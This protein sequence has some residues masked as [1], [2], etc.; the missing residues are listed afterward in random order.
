MLADKVE[1]DDL[2]IIRYIEP[3]E[4]N[5][6]A[7]GL[8]IGQESRRRAAA[9]RAMRTGKVSITGQITLVQATGGGPGFL[10]F[11]PHYAPGAPLNTIAQREYA[12]VGWV[13]MTILAERLFDGAPQFIDNELELKVFDSDG[14]ALDRVLYDEDKYLTKTNQEDVHMAFD[15]A[16]FHELVPVEIGGRE[17]IVAMNST[18]RFRAASD[19]GLWIADVAG[20]VLSG[21]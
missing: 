1:H 7:I 13:Y 9:E 6:A 3:A 14:L 20:C 2:F 18:T 12:L 8:D 17:W 5:L 4:Q 19:L 15:H 16:R 11:L 10:I 21:S